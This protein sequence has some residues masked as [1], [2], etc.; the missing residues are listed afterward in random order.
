MAR[1]HHPYRHRN[2]RR[3]EHPQSRVRFIVDTVFIWAA[4]AGITMLAMPH[5]LA[6]WNRATVTPEQRAAIEASRYFS[7][8]DA[9]RQAGA[10][11]IY[12]GSPGYRAGLDGD[13]DGIA[14]ERFY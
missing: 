9:A 6:I 7:N 11:P 14:C 5:L 12:A 1:R 4:V 10:A 2:R 3:A 8:C 13:S